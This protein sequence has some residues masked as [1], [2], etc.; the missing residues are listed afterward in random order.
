VVAL[1][2]IAVAEVANPLLGVWTWSKENLKKHSSQE[3]P[4]GA[5]VTAGTGSSAKASEEEAAPG[6]GKETG[7]ENLPS[8]GLANNENV[9]GASGKHR[10]PRSSTSSSAEVVATAAA[11][12]SSGLPTTTTD[13]TAAAAAAATQHHRAVFER[14][15]LPVTAAYALTRGVAMPLSV[16]DVAVFLF[17]GKQGSRGTPA[18]GWMWVHCCFGLAGSLVWVHM[19]VAGYLRFRAKAN[20]KTQRQLDAPAVDTTTKKTS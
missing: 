16:L 3:E 15:S 7:R 20:S 10:I 18:L 6:R 12:A 4:Q 9:Q 19:L 5:T 14:L 8:T 11:A 2:G 1:V 13:V 17:Q